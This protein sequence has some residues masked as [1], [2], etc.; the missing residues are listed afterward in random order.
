ME[1]YW[2]TFEN[3]ENNGCI[4]AASAEA[5]KEDAKQFG[6]PLKAELLPY[7]AAPRLRVRISCPAFCWTPE[8]CKGNS[9]CPRRYAC[10]E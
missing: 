7:P 9:S 5:A 4:D 1:S 8:T 2:V 6:A 10:C 3:S